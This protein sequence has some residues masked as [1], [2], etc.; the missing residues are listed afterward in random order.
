MNEL[1][2]LLVPYS[3]PNVVIVDC[4]NNQE[5][6]LYAVDSEGKGVL[7]GS[8]QRKDSN[9]WYKN[10]EFMTKDVLLKKFRLRK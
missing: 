2:R 1:E 7:I 9:D 5:S 10:C 8:L 3:V 4:S 6:V